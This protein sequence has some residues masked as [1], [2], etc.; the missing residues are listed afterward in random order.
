[1]EG[2]NSIFFTELLDDYK[3]FFS[4]AE[5]GKILLVRFFWACPDESVDMR[6]SWGFWD[7][8]VSPAVVRGC[9]V[10]RRFCSGDGGD[11]V[12]GSC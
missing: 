2:L 6:L 1:L 8:T 5:I 7:L 10:P 4:G 12:W 3:K 11:L 9:Y